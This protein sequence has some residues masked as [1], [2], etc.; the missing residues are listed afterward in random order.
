MYIFWTLKIMVLLISM[1]FL[2]TL[3]LYHPTFILFLLRYLQYLN[4]AFEMSPLVSLVFNMTV[5]F[6]RRIFSIISPS[7]YNFQFMF[8]T[9]SYLYFILYLKN[10]KPCCLH[11]SFILLSF[12][13]RTTSLMLQITSYI[14]WFSTTHSH[15]NGYC[16]EVQQSFQCFI[17]YFWSLNS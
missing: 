4:A 9:I 14:K 7:N 3:Y 11:V 2:I 10:K 16:I 5:R 15:I 8:A 6:L 17:I 1:I 13:S 12:F